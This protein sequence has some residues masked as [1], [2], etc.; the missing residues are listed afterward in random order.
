MHACCRFKYVT[1]QA[2]KYAASIP[3][4][5]GHKL[6]IGVYQTEEEAARAV[7]VTRVF[8]VRLACVWH[9]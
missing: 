8:L 4:Y 3:E 9:V 2:G 1:K 5:K 6:H 7:D